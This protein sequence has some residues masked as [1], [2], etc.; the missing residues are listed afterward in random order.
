MNKIAQVKDIR[1][2]KDKESGE[3]REFAFVEYHSVEDSKKVVDFAKREG[4]VIKGE[5][6]F[7]S[8]SKFKKTEQYVLQL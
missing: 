6:V 7:V 2:L 3:K 4:V 8:F 5:R 1:M